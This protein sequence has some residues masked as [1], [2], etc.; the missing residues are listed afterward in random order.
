MSEIGMLTKKLT[1]KPISQMVTKLGG[2]PTLTI[3]KARDIKKDIPK[4]TKMANKTS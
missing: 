1:A 2:M 3:A 4:D